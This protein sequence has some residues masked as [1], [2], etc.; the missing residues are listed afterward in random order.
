MPGLLGTSL[1]PDE[2]WDSIKSVGRGINLGGTSGLLGGPVDMATM[3]LNNP[4]MIH[5]GLLGVQGLGI[6]KPVMGSK[7]IESKLQPAGLLPQRQGNW[8]EGVGE[9]AS[10][11]INPATAA[12]AAGP[13]LYA[14]ESRILDNGFA[15]QTMNA[16]KRYQ[17][18]ALFPVETK[19][20][21]I[22]DEAEK[23]A[24]QLKDQG[25]NVDLQHS[26]SIYGPSSYLN[27]HDPQTGRTLNDIRLSNH[28]KGPWNAQFVRDVATPEEFA[29]VISDALAM[30]KQ[31]PTEGLLAQHAY[32]QIAMQKRL[33]SATKKL[34]KGAPLT[35]SEQELIDSMKGSQ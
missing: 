1:T 8:Q 10:A 9:L 6:E 17:A 24:A 2:L 13:G 30:R 7:W 27:I 21:V 14:A 16:S 15:P 23:L 33:A 4:G 3:L 28:N 20:A 22:K 12:Y 25:F 26:G 29:G 19:G 11:F 5:P 31:G 34:A 18:G 32:D 35:R